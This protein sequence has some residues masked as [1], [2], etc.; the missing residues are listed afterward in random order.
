MSYADFK[1]NTIQLTNGINT[2]TCTPNTFSSDGPFTITNV[3]MSGVTGI[4][5]NSSD[6]SSK[7]ATTEFVQQKI[8]SISITGNSENLSAEITRATA[9]EAT[10]TTNLSSEITRATGEEATLR[11]NLSTEITRASAAEAT[12]TTNLSTEI[13]RATAAEAT[14][15]ANVSALNASLANLANAS[16][17]NSNTNTINA[18]YAIL[19]ASNIFTTKQTF[20]SDIASSKYDAL[21]SSAALSL[22]SNLT[23]GNLLLGASVTNAS[24]LIGSTANGPSLSTITIGNEYTTTNLRGNTINVTTPMSVGYSIPANSL[25]SLAY[26]GGLYTVTSFFQYDITTTKKAQVPINGIPSGRYCLAMYVYTGSGSPA[27]RYETNSGYSTS[28]INPNSTS[29]FTHISSGILET[30]TFKPNNTNAMS[31]TSTSY[32]DVIP[33]NNNI[34]II[35]NSTTN[36]AGTCVFTLNVCRVA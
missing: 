36:S 2:V 1:A 5:P 6:N 14:I 20:N 34:C 11:A 3:N 24:I 23:T 30:Y 10:L 17:N 32:L 13:T 16:T 25:A 35:C 8:A 26:I 28:A 22:G 33:G 31:I 12:L 29:G 15:L 7:F 9:A 27:A 4:T 19:N 18:S 21:N